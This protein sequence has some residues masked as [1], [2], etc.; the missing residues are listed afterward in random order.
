MVKEGKFAVKNEEKEA[1][2]IN[3]IVASV[4]TIDNI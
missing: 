1:H 3:G 4:V 2:A